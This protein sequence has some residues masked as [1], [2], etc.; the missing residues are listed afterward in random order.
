MSEKQEGS[1]IQEK[2]DEIQDEDEFEDAVENEVQPETPVVQ[3][4]ETKTE[5]I[6]PQKIEED[7]DEFQDVVETPRIN[8]FAGSEQFTFSDSRTELPFKAAKSGPSIWA[9]IKKVATSDM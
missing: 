4:E 8:G 6:E 3:Q 2:Q 5:G 7:D 1:P 9:V